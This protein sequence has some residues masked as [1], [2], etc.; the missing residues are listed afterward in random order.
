MSASTAL[1]NASSFTRICPLP[2]DLAWSIQLYDVYKEITMN[3]TASN[4]DICT[5]K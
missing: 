5:D 3:I 1:L 2:S 4:T